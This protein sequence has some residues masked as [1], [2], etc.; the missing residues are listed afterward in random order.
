[1]PCCCAGPPA[2]CAAN[3]P[4]VL[5]ATFGQPAD[6]A[7]AGQLARRT[8]ARL[9][10][11]VCEANEAI[12]RERLAVRAV[13]TRSTSD[14]RLEL[15]PALRAAFVEPT[16]LVDALHIDTSLP[17]DELVSDIVRN[18]RISGKALA[19]PASEPG[20]PSRRCHVSDPPSRT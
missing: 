9:L 20:L 17:I 4:V 5:D 3:N 14:A 15:W 19:N 12:I 2:G 7:A 10:V 8:G 11:V 1:M 13:D 6:R 16:E 18:I